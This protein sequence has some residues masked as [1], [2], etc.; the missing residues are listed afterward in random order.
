MNVLFKMEN[1]IF[2]F[3]S[4]LKVR[5][6]LHEIILRYLHGHKTV[7]EAYLK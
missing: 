3:F 7:P 2:D 1:M 4:L 6:L 5:E